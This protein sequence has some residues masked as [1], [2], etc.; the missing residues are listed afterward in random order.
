MTEGPG[1]H[2]STARMAAG[3]LLRTLRWS[4][5][6]DPRAVVLI[7]HGLGEHG[8]RYDHVGRRFA[9]RGYEVHTYDQ[10]GFGGS[11]GRRAYVDRF[12]MF[13]DDLEARL[14]SLRGSHGGLPLILY[15][16]SFGGLVVTGYLLAEPPRPLPDLA[17]LSAPALLATIPPWKRSI[18]NGLGSV[19]PRLALTNDFG[20]G[21]LCR[22]PEVERRYDQDPLVVKKT[23]TRFA[24]ESFGEQARI[25]AVL[26]RGIHLP[27]PTYTFHGTAD[28]IV[29]AAAS[30]L[31]VGHG[32]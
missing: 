5:A 32:D 10:R 31:L 15:G 13:D 9:D 27:V 14:G 2:E 24:S 19:L 30:E 6:G 25:A 12:A 16:P 20:P 22:D 23:T 7:V 29:P 1:A 26:A 17:I 4:P 18:A 28:P 3:T 21:S 11:A 8:G